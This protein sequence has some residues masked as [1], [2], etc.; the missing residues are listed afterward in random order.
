MVSVSVCTSGGS[1]KSMKSPKEG[2]MASG[3]VWSQ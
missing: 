3:A 2:G 1:M